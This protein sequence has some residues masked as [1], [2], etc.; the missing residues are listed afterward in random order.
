MT[1]KIT[2][3]IPKPCHENWHEM[4]P[5][6]KGKFCSNC[7]KNV[8]DFTKSSNREIL[9]AYNK[10]ENLCGRFIVSQLNRDMIIPKEK[11]SVWMVAAA[12]IIAFLGLGNQTIKAQEKSKTEQT[13]RKQLKD[14]I[15]SKS[16]KDFVTYTGTLY[17]S[18]DN[19]L[20]GVNV[21][22]KQTKVETKTNFDGEFTIKAKKGY[23]LIFQHE[24]FLTTEFK[25]NNDI[26]IKP[27]MRDYFLTGDVVLTETEDD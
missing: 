14:S 9:L 17:D 6:E 20:P 4:S 18:Q 25:L 15:K 27:K 16:K 11:R 7:Q 24:N 22:V 13:D 12:S 26:K 2:I 3:S 19:P 8:I 5:T 10:N 23:I 1:R 21:K